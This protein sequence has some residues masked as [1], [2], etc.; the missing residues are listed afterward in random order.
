MPHGRRMN[1]LLIFWQ[2]RRT[3]LLAFEVLIG[4][5]GGGGLGFVFLFPPQASHR[6]HTHT[7]AHPC[8]HAHT[9][10]SI[11]TIHL[12]VMWPTCLAGCQPYSFSFRTPYSFIHPIP[13]PIPIPIPSSSF[14]SFYFLD[15]FSDSVFSEASSSCMVCIFVC[16]FLSWR[17]Y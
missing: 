10:P 4:G 11:N 14:R 17:R 8:T 6:C 13:I 16:V 12:H 15:H 9:H 1:V 7:A 2:T 5:R 3:D